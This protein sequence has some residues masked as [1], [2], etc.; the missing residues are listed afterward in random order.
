LKKFQIVA[1]VIFDEEV[2]TCPTSEGNVTN[3]TA[4][5]IGTIQAWFTLIG[6]YDFSSLP[7]LEYM[8]GILLFHSVNLI[9]T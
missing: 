4:K 1:T 6:K 3:D 8:T 2:I 7:V 9:I 5:I